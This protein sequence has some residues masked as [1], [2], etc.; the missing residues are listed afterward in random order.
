MVG[1]SIHLQCEA[2]YTAAQ[3]D[4]AITCQPNAEWSQPQGH[5][6]RTWIRFR[7]SCVLGALL[8]RFWCVFVF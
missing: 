6:A 7:I 3:G 5:C 2:G 1:D 8:W 4:L